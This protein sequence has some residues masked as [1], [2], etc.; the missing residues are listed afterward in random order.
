MKRFTLLAV[1]LVALMVIPAPGLFAEEEGGPEPSAPKIDEEKTPWLKGVT[2]P[3]FPPN[4]SPVIPAKIYG[5]D[6]G[7]IPATMSED[8]PVLFTVDSEIFAE[9]PPTE[10][11]GTQL[12]NGAWDGTPSV[13][14]FFAD[15]GKHRSTLASCTEILPKNQMKIMP[16][17]PCPFG[18]ISVT[19]ARPMKY[20]YSPGRFRRAYVNSSI[21]AN[22]AVTD[23][24][25]PTCGIEIKGTTRQGSFWSVENPPNGPAPKGADAFLRGSFL[26]QDGQ[27]LEIVVRGLQLDHMVVPGNQATILLP[28]DEELEIRLVLLDNDKVDE[29][30]IHYGISDGAGDEPLPVGPV[31]PDRLKLSDLKLPEKAFFF[32][33]SKDVSGNRQIFFVPVKVF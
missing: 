31:N 21:G 18:G 14:W 23:I 30:T 29:K 25:P 9:K 15:I 20:E 8:I 10:F 32:I 24:T 5:P 11:K 19:L 7:P 12:L 3:P 1:V 4:V 28:K 2:I 17:D 6:G 13:R 33:D 26:T 27:D 22:L 16:L